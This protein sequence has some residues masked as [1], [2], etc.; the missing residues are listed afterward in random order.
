MLAGVIFDFDGVIADSH[1]VHLQA[2]RAF[3]LSQGKVVSDPE[4]SFVQEGA[5]REEILRHFLG[6]ITPEQIRHY[7]HE[8]DKL[9]QARAHE[10]KLVVGF[11]EFLV[12]LDAIGLPS[13]V[14]TS[15][16]RSRVEQALDMFDLQSRFRAIVTGEDVACGKPDPALFLQAAQ[17]LQVD[18]SR[19]LVCEDAVAG[20]IAAKTAGMKCLGIARGGRGVLLKKAGA[21]LVV[22]D[23]AQTNLA[24][25]RGLFSKPDPE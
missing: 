8:K 16:S 1:P 24:D 25:V 9:F 21:G 2:W 15:G 3:L 20:V 18:P 12:Q 23:F 17:T 4:L 11:I 5:K 13:A 14:A 19:V 7:G 22:D 6:D 10:I